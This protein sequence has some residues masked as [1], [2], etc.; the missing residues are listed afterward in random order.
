MSEYRLSDL[1]DTSTVQKLADSNFK[2]TGLPMSII[3]KTDGSFLVKAGWG[4]ICTNFHRANPRSSE[5]CLISDSVV[6]DHLDE[7][8]H[9]YICKNGLRHFAMPIIVD[10]RH[11]GSL[12]LSQFWYDSDVIDQDYFINQASKYG[13]DV[14]IYLDALKR[15]P[16][17][18]RETVDYIVAYDESLARFIADLAQHSLRFIEAQKSLIESEDKYRTLVENVPIGIYRINPAGQGSFIK[19]N[20]AMVEIFGFDSSDEF[21]QVAVSDLYQSLDSRKSYMKKMQADGFVK[22]LELALKKKDGTPIWCSLTATAQFDEQRVIRLM[23]CVIEDITEGKNAQEELQIAHAELEMRVR[24]RTAELMVEVAERRR[25]EEKFREL[26]ETDHLTMIY[27]RRK[28]NDVMTIE[29]EKARRYARP[30]SLIMMDLDHFKR[31]NDTYGHSVGDSVLKAT[32]HIVSGMLRIVDVF[33]RFGGE[34]FIVLCPETDIDG[35]AALANKI[36]IA[37]EE[38]SHPV[39]GTVTVSAGVAEYNQ[40]NTGMALIEKADLALYTAKKAGRN[41]VAIASAQAEE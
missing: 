5:Q 25:F 39:A 31:V 17:F 2:A 35:A 24:E 21:M 4:G 6:N 27:N 1:L 18:C 30:L 15:M 3:D 11:L 23:D 41:R 37:M 10:G 26:S 36:R 7:A 33:A 8:S 38:F 32:A 13:F 14:D 40:N 16:F 9:H 22:D 28:L 34:E 19:V 29:I 12:F 20:P